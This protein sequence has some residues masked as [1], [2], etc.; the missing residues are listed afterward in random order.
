ML[1]PS[2]QLVLWSSGLPPDT[3]SAKPNPFSSGSL[4]CLRVWRLPRQI[5][6]DAISPE[7]RTA[8]ENGS[9]H[10]KTIL[11]QSNQPSVSV[12]APDCLRTRRHAKSILTPSARPPFLSPCLPP[13]TGPPTPKPLSHH[14]P[15]QSSGAP[16][17]LRMR[18]LPRQMHIHTINPVPAL[19]PNCPRARIR[20]QQHLFEHKWH[21]CPKRESSRA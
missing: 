20:F 17:C 21:G 3:A 5:H 10:A 6:S 11:T 12:G 19:K 7:L 1:T 2:D 8:S 15:G 18:R 13:S 9:C 4:G 14:Q 16:D